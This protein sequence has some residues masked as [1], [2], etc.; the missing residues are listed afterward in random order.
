MA[1]DLL[2]TFLTVYPILTKLLKLE[3]RDLVTFLT[4]YPILTILQVLKIRQLVP[5]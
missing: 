2:I 1:N 3:K 4:A 5:K